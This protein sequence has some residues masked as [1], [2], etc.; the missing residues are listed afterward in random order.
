MRIATS[1][2]F[3]GLLGFAVAGATCA[4]ASGDTITVDGAGGAD[5]I[6]IQA[7]M[8]AA[9]DG[10]EI[11]VASGNYTATGPA[12]VDFLGKSVRLIAVAG[13]DATSITA[14]GTQ[15]GVLFSHGETAG[16]SL[17][18][19]SV[20]GGDAWSAHATAI[21]VVDSSPSI[22]DCSLGYYG[23]WAQALSMTNSAAH[24]FDCSMGGASGHLPACS[25]MACSAI[26]ERCSMAA[27][28]VGYLGMA[29]WEI[30]GGGAIDAN[31]D[32]SQF[33]DC[34]FE[35]SRRQGPGGAV[36]LGD[37]SSQFVRCSFINNRNDPMTPYTYFSSGAA[38]GAMQI[39]GSNSDVSLDACYFVGNYARGVGY[40]AWHTCVSA[41]SYGGA[42]VVLDGSLSITSCLFHRNS[43][44]ATVALSNG[45]G[46]GG[47][48][49]F[50]GV[51]RLDIRGTVFT[52]N[53]ARHGGAIY[54][55][56]ATDT[57]LWID[58]CRFD[59][60]SVSS[61]APWFAAQGSALWSGQYESNPAV[62]FL[63]SS[64][65][66]SN[67]G[68]ATGVI[69]LDN[70]SAIAARSFLVGGVSFCGNAAT[71][72]IG[73]F[74]ELAPNC[75]STDCSDTN[76]DGVPDSCFSTVRVDCNSNGI[77]DA[78]ELAFGMA[79]DLD[80][81]GRLDSCGCFGDLDSDHWVGGADLVALLTN[82]GQPGPRPEDLDG[83]GVV[84]A[85]DMG[86][87]LAAWGAC[88]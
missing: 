71:P 23:S 14:T 88:P 5:F 38:G 17:I 77:W 27:S 33:A 3:S 31:G 66:Q 37:A 36:R 24:V 63:S 80:G 18:G 81:D 86:L 83:S 43:A 82:W 34:I 26:F 78:S 1:I 49:A 19:F 15:A 68:S 28:L 6:S 13:R 51:G 79:S 70:A 10:D 76:G 75:E 9:H 74:R 64:H 21:R 4:G 58:A 16:A 39:A 22:S 67:G 69:F 8:D 44:Q 65:F 57:G 48:V 62:R 42:I 73:G 11:R 7:A 30:D 2:K 32:R 35:G 59:S 47:A 53:E 40:C 56:G 55:G 29:G 12:V 20:I 60:N 85:G 54:N 46:R 52:E 45:G 72:V 84:D 87:L 25:L 50:F 61:D 41:A